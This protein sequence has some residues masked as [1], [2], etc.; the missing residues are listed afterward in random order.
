MSKKSFRNF[1]GTLIE[2]NIKPLHELT[3]EDLIEQEYVIVGGPDTVIEQLEKFQEESG[4]G[5]IVGAGGQWGAM[6]VWMAMKNMQIMAEQVMPHFR[7]P[8]GKPIW[9]R[10]EPK[11]PSTLSEQA[12]T[13]APALAPRIRFDDDTYMDPRVGHIPE[14]VEAARNQ[15]GA[16]AH[17]PSAGRWDE[18]D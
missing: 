4:A 8:D 18:T 16:T 6:P 12:A 2:K 11:V 5:V 10:A 15:V 7:P 14:E 1:L 3:Y 17:G 13:V 9:A